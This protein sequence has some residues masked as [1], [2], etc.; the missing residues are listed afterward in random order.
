MDSDEEY[1]FDEFDNM[2]DMFPSDDYNDTY[3]DVFAEYGGIYSN[4]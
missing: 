4:I 3:K 2:D 1:E